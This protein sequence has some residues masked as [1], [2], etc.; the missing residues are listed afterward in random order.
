MQRQ[1]MMLQESVIPRYHGHTKAGM[2]EALLE[3][4]HAHGQ[5]HHTPHFTYA[6]S[7]EVYNHL[8]PTVNQTNIPPFREHLPL[9]S[10]SSING[11]SKLRDEII[12]Q[13]YYEIRNV[14]SVGLRFFNVYGPW[15]VP[16]STLFTLAEQQV[17]GEKV[18]SLQP[19]EL[20]DVRDYIYIDD[21]VDAMLATMQFRAPVNA[22]GQEAREVRVPAPVVINVG[23]G[24]GTTLRSVLNQM[25]QLFPSSASVDAAS[26]KRAS[27]NL[28]PTIS[29]ASIERAEAWLGF[30]PQVSLQQG[31]EKL[32]AWHYD[33]AFPYGG[34]TGGGKR[35]I[36]SSNRGA[37]VSRIESQGI[38]GCSKADSECFRGTPS[39]WSV[40][41]R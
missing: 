28:S 4:I 41:F 31:L 25:S 27:E 39:E 22:G 2:M 14:Y 1:R 29:F 20:D 7:Y 38:V 3:Q 19:D 9:T 40:P 17:T 18:L 37:S 8:R 6:S 13:L 16:G 23:T 33:R 5:Q 12:A 35:S 30:A 10:P 32:L 26:R 34:R 21:A 11:A 36:L 24:V 15:G